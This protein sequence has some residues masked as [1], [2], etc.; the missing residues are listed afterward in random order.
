[1]CDYCGK[2]DCACDLY[3]EAYKRIAYWN[4]QENKR[5]ARNLR[6]TQMFADI[7]PQ[8]I[9]GPNLVFQADV[10]PI[11]YDLR[12]IPRAQQLPRTPGERGKQRKAR[13]D[14]LYSAVKYK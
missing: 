2:K 14:P 8:H 5:N 3:D 9:L 11:V 7:V 1:M 12:P 13:R 6:K 4:Q 10:E